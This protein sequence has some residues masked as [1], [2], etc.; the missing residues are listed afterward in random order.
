MQLVLRKATTV[1][2]DDGYG[3]TVR[4]L[5]RK[6]VGAPGPGWE[7]IPGGKHGGWRKRGAAG[8]YVYKY[9]SKEAASVAVGHHQA[10]M[11]HHR[12]RRD[13]HFDKQDAM[14]ETWDHHVERE[15]HHGGLHNT[16]REIARAAQHY[17]EHGHGH[18][19]WLD[20]F[21]SHHQRHDGDYLDDERVRGQVFGDP[22]DPDKGYEFMQRGASRTVSVRHGTM[23]H[24]A[25]SNDS[26]WHEVGRGL[27]SEARRLMS[28]H[29]AKRHREA[30][31]KANTARDA[32]AGS[33]KGSQRP[34][35]KARA[36]GVL[37]SAARPSDMAPVGGALGPPR[38][39]AASLRQDANTHEI[40][41]GR[42]RLG[43]HQCRFQKG[44]DGLAVLSISGPK[45]PLPYHMVLGPQGTWRTSMAKARE[46][47]E[48]LREGRVPTEG[49]FRRIGNSL[50]PR[51]GEK[52]A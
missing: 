28:D 22:L 4:F 41:D 10:K 12:K 48:L 37:S 18:P 13:H 50:T 46:A 27:G 15:Q 33:T 51:W 24:G 5:L 11:A 31:A 34:L 23:R 36:T 6:G 26:T 25:L 40:I 20:S 38:I 19:P 16:H 30:Q 47:I 2:V 21:D 1:R 39:E 3:G 7:A 42:Y 45:M 14:D 52:T 17:A 35:F 44:A 9:P 32:A 49:V 29:V 8:H 43:T